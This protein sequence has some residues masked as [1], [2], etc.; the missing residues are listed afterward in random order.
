MRAL[1]L[2]EDSSKS[3]QEVVQAFYEKAVRLA[4]PNEYVD[5]RTL[6][7]DP[8]TETP[9]GAKRP[10]RAT[11]CSRTWSAESWCPCVIY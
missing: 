9:A 4:R 11:T 5:L 8:S 3:G 2:T 10:R 7:F 1:V 6:N